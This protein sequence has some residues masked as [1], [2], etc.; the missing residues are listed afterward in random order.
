MGKIPLQIF[1]EGIRKPLRGKDQSELQGLTPSSRDL[2]LQN[3]ETG[4]WAVPPF[5]Q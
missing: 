2:C 1:K 5:C 3:E 4:L